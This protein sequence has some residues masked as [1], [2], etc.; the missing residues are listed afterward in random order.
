MHVIQGYNI[1]IRYTGYQ[2]YS[3]LILG[4]FYWLTNIFYTCLPYV[5]MCCKIVDWFIFFVF[6]A[7]NQFVLYMICFLMREG[8]QP[9]YKIDVLMVYL[10]QQIIFK[11]LVNF[12]INIILCRC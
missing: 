10:D 4:G 5:S 9:H 8:N 1:K 3:L 2:L 12:I 6:F 7:V 11:F